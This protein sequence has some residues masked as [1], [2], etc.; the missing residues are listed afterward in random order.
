MFK[1]IIVMRLKKVGDFRRL[2]ETLSKKN[3]E[4]TT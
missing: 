1:K 3:G 4:N 2:E